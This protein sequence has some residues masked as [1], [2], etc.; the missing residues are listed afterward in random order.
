[1]SRLKKD[2]KQFKKTQIIIVGV[3]VILLLI[4]LLCLLKI[5]FS[6]GFIDRKELLGI[7]ADILGGYLGFI[8]A[9]FT[10]TYQMK[11]DKENKIEEMNNEIEYKK[12]M[13][14]TLLD[15]TIYHTNDIYKQLDKYYNDSIIGAISENI[16]IIDILSKDYDVNHLINHKSEKYEIKS[17]LD[18]DSIGIMWCLKYEQIKFLKNSMD[19]YFKDNILKYNNIKKLVYDKNWTDYIDCLEKIDTSN[20]IRNMQKIINWITLL[21]N[22]G[23]N[24]DIM[25]FIMRRRGIRILIDELYPKARETGFRDSSIYL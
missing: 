14:F 20:T 10:L 11:Q 15:Y 8:I 4:I 9:Y 1:M 25:D 22:N 24:Y 13:L 7:T 21:E 16:D 3:F 17:E 23:E 6:W 5:E 19:L 18:N 2:I 12:L